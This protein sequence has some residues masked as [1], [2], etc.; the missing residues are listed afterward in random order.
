MWVSSKVS[1]L[2]KRASQFKRIFLLSVALSS[3]DVDK[4]NLAS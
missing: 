2:A 1:V 4:M 3:S